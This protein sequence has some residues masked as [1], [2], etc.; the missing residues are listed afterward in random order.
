MSSPT[1][2]LFQDPEFLFL[3]PKEQGEVLS[4]ID[5]SF[6]QL[7]P[8][9]QNSVIGQVQTMRPE[10][11]TEG[12]K[13]SQRAR[14]SFARD[15]ASLRST[16][17]RDFGPG[18]VVKTPQGIAFRE[19]PTQP[20]TLLDE[21]GF[22]FGDIADILGD[23]PQIAG[24]TIGALMAGGTTFG[25]GM[26][27]GGAG[28][29]ALGEVA[30]QGIGTMMGVEQGTP[31]QQ[32]GDLASS[33]VF[34]TVAELGGGLVA[35]GV[36]GV[37]AGF[38]RSV[39]PKAKQA[40][41]FIN[42][43]MD[44][45]LGPTPAQATENKFL[46]IMENIVEGGFFGGRLGSFKQLQK[47]EIEGLFQVTARQFSDTIPDSEEMGRVIADILESRFFPQKAPGVTIRENLIKEMPEWSGGI[48]A[49]IKHSPADIRGIVKAR[50]LNL[51]PN[52]NGNK[53]SLNLEDTFTLRS[54]I[55]ALIRTS[56]AAQAVP[57]GKK[58]AIELRELMGLKSTLNT[59]F[60]KSLG[61]EQFEKVVASDKIFGAA[62]STYRNAFIKKL[63]R[64]GVTKPAPGQKAISVQGLGPQG[65]G[66]DPQGIVKQLISER[67]TDRIKL[68]KSALGEGSQEWE[69]F[70]AYAW[71]NLLAEASKGADGG[72][73]AKALRVHVRGS[74]EAGA[75]G[76][77]NQAVRELWGE[78]GAKFIDEVINVLEIQK[79]ATEAVGKAAIQFAQVTSISGLASGL[80]TGSLQ[81]GA[82]FIV[83]GPL[84]GGFMFTNPMVRRM[85]IEGMKLPAGSPAAVALTTRLVSI[86]SEMDTI[87]VDHLVEEDERDQ[88]S[89]RRMGDIQSPPAP[90]SM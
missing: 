1:L 79:P 23:I 9:D 82:G 4:V 66:I 32:L 65:V 37:L 80:L 12:A 48:D 26:V 62:Q 15:E 51:I 84:V 56:K 16:L 83:F 5:P 43:F 76:L 25:A 3:S 28:G 69:Q 33:A 22:S 40:M 58:T 36:G 67:P 68:V 81:V 20:F 45:H 38:S 86:V 6:L 74:G 35:K 49:I 71:S 78:E 10:L 14:L 50:K 29:T 54:E 39:S 2:P 19:D 77:G 27:A 55:N 18:N 64:M 75:G 44:P 21:P 59:E 46:D 11:N 17:E 57:T 89:I 42:E 34:G 41:R 52:Q 47:D 73:T 60:K 53:F 31:Q 24:G 72:L 7:P 87:L 13:F 85:L 88:Q 8:E 70:Q 61:A 30:R 90:F 63:I